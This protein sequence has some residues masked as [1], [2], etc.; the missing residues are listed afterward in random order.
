MKHIS[1]E[2]SE[3]YAMCR[4]S[5]YRS[6]CVQEHL[7]SCAVCQERLTVEYGSR[8]AMK[9]A[10]RKRGIAKVRQHRRNWRR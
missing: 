7:R 5:R 1:E 6:E 9:E 3:E 4:L 10:G 2:V 8:M